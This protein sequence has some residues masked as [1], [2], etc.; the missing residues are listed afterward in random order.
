MNHFPH[1]EEFIK[2]L[3]YK[4]VLYYSIKNSIVI[5]AT[6]VYLITFFCFLDYL[7]PLPI[8]IR[9]MYW[10]TVLFL[11]AGSL[12][13]IVRFSQIT[14]PEKII[15]E[16]QARYSFFSDDLINAWCL[17]K[18][19]EIKG[20]SAELID[21]FIEN[22]NRSI[23]NI[24]VLE[25]LNI[26]KLTKTCR[27][28][29]VSLII[30]ACICIVFFRNNVVRILYP[31]VSSEFIRSMRIN[32]G[33][34][35]VPWG[36]DV[37]IS[38]E[39]L[40]PAR[41]IPYVVIRTKKTSPVEYDM[42]N[43]GEKFI[44]EVEHISTPNEYFI[45]WKGL[46]SQKYTL[47]P[48]FVPKLGDFKL[49]Y[50]FPSYTGISYKEGSMLGEMEYLAGTRIEFSA[51]SN[52]LL[53]KAVLKNSW[54]S[55]TIPLKI[56]GKNKVSGEFIVEKN[57]ECW[58]EL[59][60]DDAMVDSAP[61]HY[62]IKIKKDSIPEITILS[63]GQNLVVSQDSKVNLIYKVN[64]DFGVSRVMLIYRLTGKTKEDKI[65]LRR[66][67]AV[68][69]DGIF[70]YQ[71]D[72]SGIKSNPGD[73]IEYF[74][75]VFDN[76]TISGPKRSVSNTYELKIYSYEQEHAQIESELKDFRNELLKLL[77]DQT[78]LESKL[79]KL[80]ADGQL[81]S[82]KEQAEMIQGQEKIKEDT[83]N[84]MQKISKLL[85][86]MELDPY[87]NYQVFSEHQH[88]Q[89]SLESLKQNQL[90]ETVESLND[91]EF[92]S[93]DNL[94]DEIISNLEHLN[95]IAEDVLQYQKMED[96]INSSEKMSQMGE[97]LAEGLK[98][99]MSAEKAKELG[100]IVDK[101]NEMM[102]EIQD[103]VQKM[104]QDLPEEFVN[105]PAVK[106]IDFNEMSSFSQGLKESLAKG[107]YENALR[108]A[109]ELLGR[110]KSM[111]ETF[112]NA[113]GDVGFSS[114][115]S[116]FS[117]QM[118]KEYVELKSIITEQNEIL[119]ETNEIEKF[120]Q[121]LLMEKQKQLLSELSK[122][123][124]QL[125]EQTR[126]FT[127][128]SKKAEPKDIGSSCMFYRDKL[129]PVM[130]KIYTELTLQKIDKSQEWLE[131]VIK[132]LDSLEK[133][134][135]DY[136]PIVSTHSVNLYEETVSETGKV[137]AGEQQIL[138][139]LKSPT[140]VEFQANVQDR[141]KGL[142][143]RQ[144][145]LKSRTVN[146]DREVQ[147]M[148][149]SSALITPDI[150]N[151]LRKAAHEMDNAQE[152]LIKG[153]TDK[154]VINERQ[155]L[156]YLS[157]GDSGMQNSMGSQSQIMKQAGKPMAGFMQSGSQ[158]GGGIMGIRSGVVV[159]PGLDEYTPPKEFREE[160]LES[161]RE[162][163]PESYEKII[164]EYYKELSK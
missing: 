112:K 138:D 57:G 152:N 115:D 163:Y 131:E 160:L 28:L 116:A 92:V 23:S 96:L 100:E 93:A 84:L 53:K 4:R 130:D 61:A 120:R 56:S 121:E 144:G 13:R 46:R 9:F 44:Y 128:K 83:G 30:S 14:G 34:V 75:E 105:Q 36:S 114:A 59:I 43:T 60:S 38:V 27:F 15:S 31:S 76:D 73:T 39:L 2:K 99:K 147:K 145:T 21:A 90:S 140:E 142:S 68:L 162:K 58:F 16:L 19:E 6:S 151:N 63:P 119:K 146:L 157:Q 35:N 123:Q 54:S 136:K 50:F 65:L 127:E 110:A 42:I 125:M 82:V 78:N 107:D 8:G 122:K 94:M 86:R 103:L 97:S 153:K 129:L 66:F 29:T 22:V 55:Q 33:S 135:K 118:E 7:L 45:K 158:Q 134:L 113:R 48:L 26:D 150:S 3:R 40:T 49:K 37:E 143:G 5:I 69:T 81:P 148:S 89:K 124:K 52:K 155:A 18:K 133:T 102:K 11:V 106:K 87:T 98:G 74:L 156:E 67:D 111:L 1:I 95:L 141:L 77:G 12:I 161:L 62:Q 139:V 154:S 126:G 79:S 47:N 88:I 41:Y 20:V 101:I 104:P 25:Y 72:I 71:W 24:P 80:L 109:K 70:E 132:Q 10:G 137:K 108:L 117:E 51:V 91:R 32:P 64:D 159:L 164:K 85:S 17:G 149:R